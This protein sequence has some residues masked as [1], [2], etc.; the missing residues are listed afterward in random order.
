MTALEND[1]VIIYV[2]FLTG[3]SPTSGKIT[4]LTLGINP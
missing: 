1:K 3:T 2:F 4:P